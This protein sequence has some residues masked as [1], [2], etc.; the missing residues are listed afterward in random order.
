MTYNFYHQTEGF[1]LILKS[2]LP[3]E[4]KRYFVLVGQK[5]FDSMRKV[6][7]EDPNDRFN[8]HKIVGYYSKSLEFNAFDRSSISEKILRMSLISALQF[9]HYDAYNSLPRDLKMNSVSSL[10]PLVCE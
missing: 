3:P 5:M 7:V 10:S 1:A 6:A 9:E 2:G 4:V 8:T